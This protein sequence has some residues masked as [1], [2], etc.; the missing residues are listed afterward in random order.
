MGRDKAWLEI[1]GVSFIERIIGVLKPVVGDL[2]LIANEP[3]YEQLGYQ[4]LPDERTGIGPAEAIRTALFHS[5][6]SILVLVG[7]D[8]PF[9]TTD[10]FATLLSKLEDHQVVA[11]L[12]PGGM[13]EPLCAV[14]NKNALETFTFLIDAGERKISRF[15]D[16]LN[17]RLVPFDEL[18]SLAGSER[19]FFNVN[20]PDDYD[21][22]KRLLI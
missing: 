10:L 19:F 3:A 15:Y 6:T 21:R 13:L 8:L 2:F 14:Y 18:K 9:V 16:R 12:G 5:P 4:V 1:G 11:P 20:S 7:C 17:T 22:A